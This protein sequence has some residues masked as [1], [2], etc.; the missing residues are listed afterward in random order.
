MDCVYGAAVLAGACTCVLGVD[1]GA[2]VGF[3]SGRYNEPFSPQA[4]RLK[5]QTRAKSLR[6][7]AICPPELFWEIF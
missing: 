7:M 6:N 1:I 4:D 3:F 5:T 2:G